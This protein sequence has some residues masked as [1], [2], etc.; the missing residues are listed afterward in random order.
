MIL[1]I[2]DNNLQKVAF[3]DNNKQGTLNFYN[4]KWTRYL[5]KASSLFE[6]TVFKQTIQTDVVPYQTTNAL[7]DRSFVS[8]VYKGRTYLFNVMTIEETEHTITC[9]CKDLNLELT[10]EYTNP[11]KSDKARTFKEYCDVMGLLEF[12]TLRIGV[13]EISDQKRTLG[14]E[15]QDTKLNRILSLANKFDAEVD[16]EVKL[17]ANG[18]IKDFILNVYREHDDKHQGVGKVRSDIILKKGK[19]IRSI[20]RKID[21]TDLIVNAIRPTAQGENGQEITIAGLGPWEVKNEN[22]VVEFFQQGDMLYAPISMQKYPSTWTG[23]TG[24]RD[25][26]TRKDITVD[27][28]SKETLR[29]QAYKEL[30]RSAYP[31]VT[32][33]I[34]GYVDLEI[35]DTA[36]VYNG[37]FYPALLLEVRVSEQTIS[38]TKP[39][40]NK[41]VFDNV[42][43][44]KS[45]LSSGIQERWQELFEASK[46]YLIKLAT[47]NGVIFK[48]GIGQSIVT[49]TL[50]KGGRPI[51]ANV[52]WRWS[53][54]GAVKTGMTYTV[55]GADVT[56]TS[57]LTVAA[58]IGNDEVAV[59]ELTFVNVLDGRDGG[60][61]PKGDPGQRGADGLP[62]RDGVGIRSTTVTY[63]SSTNGT[64]APTTGWTAAVPTVAPGNYLWTKTVWTYTDGN[65]ETGY[66][67]SRIGRDGNTGRD[68]IAG[69]DGVGIRSTTITYGKSTSGTIQPTSWTSQVP[70]VPNG[71]FLW[72]KTVWAYTDNTSE[73]GYS[74]AKMGEIGPTGAKGDRGATGP[75]GLQGPAGPQGPR[76]IQGLQGPKGDQGIAGPKGADGRTQYTHIAYADNATGGGFSQTDHTKAYIGMY[77]DFNATDSTNPSSYRWSPWKGKDGKDG[78]PGP[79]GEDGRTPYIHWAYSDNADGTG[80][81][82]SDNG[83]RYIG[84]Y[85][86]YTQADSTDKTKYRWADRWARLKL[87][88]N[89]LLNSSFNQNLTQWQGTGVTIVGGKARIT[90]EF[91]KTKDIYQS[92][93][94]QTANDDVSQVYIASISVKVSNYA[95]GSINP[96]LALYISGIKNDS[97]KTW[98]GATYLTPSHLEAVNNKGIVQFTTTFKVNVPRSQIDR[99]DFHIYARDFT[100]EVE[101]EKVSLRRGNIDLGWQASPEDLQNQLDT[102]ADQ[103]LTQ[104]QLNA[105]NERAQILDAELKAKASMDAL[106]DLEKA[107]QSFV[108]SNADSRAKAEADLAEA[109]RRIELLVT[110]FGGF[111]ELKTFIDT[112]MSSSNEG[113]IIGKNDAS[114]TIKVSSDRISM[115]SSGKEVMYIS[116]GVIHIDNGIFTASVQIGKFRTEQYHLNADMNVI[117]YVG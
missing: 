60:V 81:T 74:V 109:G 72:T 17:N 70:S 73:T 39:S 92:I 36:K 103:V 32:Y 61:G 105:L 40:T 79:K 37:D 84:H 95:A 97:A 7:N 8:F 100:G 71:Q 99:I 110:Q 50:Y 76:G 101:F 25:K 44:L 58:Y 38:F 94:S 45:K 104:E 96:Y 14:W 5:S 27:T 19:N 108:K 116:Q 26:Y 52:T 10:N 33:E 35:G 47:D 28:K 18:T 77:Q 29:T 43:A 46:P 11:F 4:D 20:K 6:F 115:F 53:L 91:N 1:T 48:N 107:Y 15:G 56:D 16:F 22:G 69:K 34:D 21:K 51:T 65:T 102:K 83:Q 30:M 23:S 62:G 63:A 57:T 54:D 59:D 87:E 12:A 80:L 98:F 64:T 90:G 117:R 41:T 24:N 68:G 78:V 3:I 89:L 85:S 55:R 114:S 82:T 75:Q 106:S 113:L 49:P 13:N 66:T 112:Y 67:V 2:H 86:D 31:S 88:D 93:K 42:R 111:K 9:T